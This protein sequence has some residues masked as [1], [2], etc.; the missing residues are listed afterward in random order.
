MQ[1]PQE[2]CETY[3]EFGFL[4]LDVETCLYQFV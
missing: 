4:Q 1:M 3:A 2:V